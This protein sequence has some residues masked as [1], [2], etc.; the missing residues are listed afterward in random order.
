MALSRAHIHPPLIAPEHAQTE[1]EA[2][3]AQ[4]RM[5]P[6]RGHDDEVA[7]ALRESQGQALG[8]AGLGRL[9]GPIERVEVGQARVPVVGG[10]RGVSE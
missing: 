5:A 2:P 7:R 3:V 9:V 8:Q 4:R 10:T 6:L 1:R